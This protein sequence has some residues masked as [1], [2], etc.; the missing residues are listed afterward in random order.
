MKERLLKLSRAVAVLI[1][2]AVLTLP[3]GVVFAANLTSPAVIVDDLAE[4]ITPASLYGIGL[5]TP[6]Q[7]FYANG[8]HWVFYINDDSDFVYKSAPENGVFNSETTIVAT[9]GIYG[10]EFAV[11]YDAAADRIHY[12]RHDMNDPADDEVVY[13]MGTPASTGVITWAAVEQTVSTTPADLITWRTTIMV[14]EAGYPWVAWIDTD[15]TNAEGIV[16]IESSSTKNGTW[17]EDVTQRCGSGGIAV[18]GTGTMTGSPVTLSPGVNDETVTVEGTFT[19]TLPI[20]GTGTATSDG[21]TITGSPVA[22]VEGVNT[23]T[24]EEGGAGTIELDLDLDDHAWF[25]QLSPIG[26]SG[27]IIEVQW[28]A[29][30]TASGDVGLYA[31]VYN[32]GT[33]TWDTRDTVVAEGSLDATRPDGFSF[34]DSGSSMWVAYTDNTGDVYSR[35]RSSIQT[36]AACA[37]ATK[38]IDQL[39]DPW[40]P[41][42]SVYREAQSGLGLDLILIVHDVLDLKYSIYDFDTTTWGA[43][44]EI[45]SVPDLVNDTISRHVASYS[46]ESPLGF[47]WQWNDDTTS[48]DTVMYWW[49]ENGQLGWYEGLPNTVSPMAEMT[50]LVFVGLAVLVFLGLAFS[51]NL[52]LKMIIYM[53]IGIFLVLAFIATM[54]SQINF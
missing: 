36:W 33:T 5:Q 18:D 42:M 46:A 53:A 54:N 44:T 20:G 26:S 11:W 29:E 28:S 32:D 24:V 34:V 7:T 25:V 49:I 45:W 43:F 19:I 38:R 47:A 50:V 12:S 6:R 9:T 2:A 15:G 16:Y 39:G 8:R 41:T 48:E 30:D 17:T 4:D 21:W 13:R 1:M 40:L 23:I 37:A 52:N 27:D 3:I 10:V 22:L 51:D 35:V 14:D 31:T